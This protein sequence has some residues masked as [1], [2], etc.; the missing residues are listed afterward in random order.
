ML[1]DYLASP[2][3]YTHTIHTYLACTDTEL[4]V[5][6]TTRPALQPVPGHA[7]FSYVVLYT[8]CTEKSLKLAIKYLTWALQHQQ[9]TAQQHA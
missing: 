7:Q 8:L 5:A 2:R 3:T 4:T 1:A 9:L 6:Y